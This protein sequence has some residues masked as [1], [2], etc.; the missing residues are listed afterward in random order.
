MEAHYEANFT[1][2]KCQLGV[3]RAGE[4]LVY[5]SMVKMKASDASKIHSYIK[6]RLDKNKSVK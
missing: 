4:G 1:F 3:Q 6:H 5:S 2:P